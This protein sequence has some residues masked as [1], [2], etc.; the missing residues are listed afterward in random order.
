MEKPDTPYLSQ[1][2]KL[3]VNSDKSH[4]WHG[5]LM[6]MVLLWFSSPKHLNLGLITRK[7]SGKSLFGEK[8]TEHLTGTPHHF[9][10]HQKQGKSDKLS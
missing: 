1:V 2:I 10:G 6:K 9:K 4:V 3:N 5:P 7:T 8:S